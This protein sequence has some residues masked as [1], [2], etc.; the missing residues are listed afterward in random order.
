MT[1]RS[2]SRSSAERS[3]SRRPRTASPRLRRGRRQRGLGSTAAPS[4]SRSRR[5]PGSSRTTR[6][7]GEDRRRPPAR[8]RTPRSRCRNWLPP[9]DRGRREVPAGRS[10]GLGVMSDAL[11][12]H[13]RRR[14]P[15]ALHGVTASATPSATL[16][17]SGED[18]RGVASG[19]PEASAGWCEPRGIHRRERRSRAVTAG[20][21]IRVRGCGTSP[22]R[23]ERARS[24]T[25]SSR[26]YHDP[27]VRWTTG[28]SF[29]GARATTRP[30]QGLRPAD[31][32][33]AVY[34]R[35]LAADV[36]APDGAGSTADPDLPTRSRSSC[37][38]PT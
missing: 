17:A 3:P 15:G 35:W 20:R 14:R 21:P 4:G 7:G 11:A 9:R 5:E 1:R 38:R 34:A 2:S 26:W 25:R 22:R 23:D 37:R 30:A 16:P 18:R 10:S 6:P 31:V 12:R 29:L 33:G 27:C 19:R 13:R 32:E 8:A 36:F 24:P 28:R